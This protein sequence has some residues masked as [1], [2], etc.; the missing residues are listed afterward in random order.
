[1]ESAQLLEIAERAARAAAAVLL[2]HGRRA[3]PGA[4]STKSS[5]TDLVSEADVAAERAIREVLERERPDDAIVG[6]EGEDKAGDSGVRWVIDPLD[7]TVNF[8]FG[9]P[10]WSVSVASEGAARVGVILDP[11]RGE[12]FRAGRRASRRCSTASRSLRRRARTCRPR[13]SR[14]DSA[15]TPRARRA[16]G[17]G[18]RAAAAGARHPAP[19]QR[20]ARPR[21]DCRRPLRRLL[22]AR[23]AALGRRRGP[24]ALRA[25]RARDPPLRR[26]RR[27]AGRCARRAAAL[28]GPLEAIVG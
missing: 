28:A 8:L 11:P 15:T 13:W 23:R 1:M 4:I 25:R 12:C 21:L 27:A 10:Q 5:P 22:R 18:R 26:A 19:G 24:A 7:G 2:D 6:E 16:G 20:R 3:A 9:I 17:A 14:Q